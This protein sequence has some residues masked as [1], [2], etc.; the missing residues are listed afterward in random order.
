MVSSTI[1]KLWRITATVTLI[2]SLM[3]ALPPVQAE[4]A[5]MTHQVTNV[6]DK[7][8]AVTWTTSTAETGYVKYGTSAESLPSIASD[9]RGQTTEDDTHHVSI[10]SLTANTTY[11][12]EI[13]SGGTTYN[14]GGSPYE[15][16]TGPGLLFAMPEMI[17]GTVYKSDGTTAAEGTMLYAQIGTSQVLSGLVG[18]NGTWGLNI[19]PIRN[20]T[21]Q[22]YYSHAD[23]DDISLDAD[24]SADGTTSQTVTITQAKAGTLEMT[25][26]VSMAADFSADVLVADVDETIQFTDAT[27]GGVSPYTYEWDFNN[28]GT[29]DSTEASPTHAYTSAGTYTVSLTV[30]DDESAT[31]TKTR[32][33]Y[34][35][36]AEPLVAGFSADM[37]VADIDETI[38]FTDA[39]TGGT[40]PYTYR[41]DFEN[42]GTVD[43][44]EASPTHAYSSAGTYTVKLTVFDSLS[45]TDSETKTDYIN[46]AQTLAAAFSA[47]IVVADVDENIQFTDATAGG[48]TPY[49]YRWDFNNDGTIDSAEASPTHAY[50]SAGTYTVKLTVFD[51]VMR[52]DSE[53][54]TNYIT[55]PATLVANFTADQTEADIG[56]TI[57]FTNTSTGGVATFTYAWDFN[58]DGTI[59]STAANP[60]HVYTTDD[61]YTVS[62]TVTDSRSSEDAETKS[63]YITALPVSIT[64]QLTNIGDKAFTVTWFTSE[65]AVG[66]VKYGTSAGSLTNTASDDRGQATEDDTHHVSITGL[67]ANTTYYYVIV[68]GGITYNNG[69][70][71]YEVTTGPSL[72]FPMPEMINGTVYKE[73]GTTPAEGAIVYA[74][75]GTSQVLSGLADNSGTWGLS[76][77]SV[78]AADFQSYYTHADE[79]EITLQ[80][81]GGN[82]G[83]ASQ[84]VTIAVA[85]A[86]T[87]EMTLMTFLTADFTAN[88]TD[89]G[90]GDTIQ[91]TNLT[92]G[93][94]SPYTYEWDFDNDGTTDSTDANPSHVYTSSGTYTV[95]L[96]VTDNE[97]D[98][99]SETKTDYITVVDVLVSITVFPANPEI[100][101][102]DQLQFKAIGTSTD[103]SKSDITASAEINWTSSVTT[104]ADIAAGTGLASTAG[105][106]AGTTVITATH[107]GRSISGNTTLT[108]LADKVAPVVT[109]ASPTEGLVLSATSLTVSGNVDDTTA[110]ATVIVNGGT[111]AALSLD[112]SGDFSQA[113]VLSV[114]SNTVLVKAVDTSGNTGT[115]GTITVVVDPNKPDITITSP[116]ERALTNNA[117][118][119]VT[120]TIVGAE[121]GKLIFN[122]VSQTLT[123]VSG[124]FTAEVTLSEG[125]NVIVV[126]AYA[127]DHE[128]EA[129]YLGTSGVRIIKLDTTAAVITI[130]SPASG[131]VVNKAGIEV[132]GTVDDPAVTS[133][134]VTLN[135]GTPQAVSVVAGSFSTVITLEA[136]ANTIAVA[137]TDTAGNSSSNTV[138]ATLDTTK[139]RVTITSPANQLLTKLT[140]LDV[141]GTIS[142]TAITTAT[143]LLNGVS[144]SVTVTNGSFTKTVTLSS[145]VNTIEVTAT[146]IASNTGT[147]GEITVTVDTTSPKLT[148]GLNDPTDSITITVTS[149]E[150]LQSAPTITVEPVIDPAGTVQKIDINKW[151]RTD[152]SSA[153]PIPAGSYTITV[154]GTDKA[155]NTTT[156]TVTFAKQTIDVDG[157][158]PTTVTTDATTLEIE[159]ETAVNDADISVTQHLENPSGNAANPEGVTAAAVFVEIVA[160]PE[161]RDNLKQIYIEVN[162]DPDELPSGTDESTLRL[163]IW[164]VAAGIW[165]QVTESGVNTTENYIYG[166]ITHLSKYGGFGSIPAP[167][168]GGYTPYVPPSTGTTDVSSYV[169][170]EGRFMQTVRAY[171]VSDV[172][173][174]EIDIGTIGLQANGDPLAIITILAIGESPFAPAG[175]TIV[176]RVYDF[177]PDGATFKPA[178]A[179]TVKYIPNEFPAGV[180]EENLVLAYRDATTGEWV[181]LEGSVVDTDA[182]TI[183][184][185]VSH[186]TAFAILSSPARPA[187]ISVGSLTI[188]PAEVDAGAPVTISVTVSN[189]SDLEGDYQVILSINDT[190]V[191]TE[192]VTLAGGASQEV[193]FTVTRAVAGDYAVTIGDLSGSFTVTE[194]PVVTEPEGASAEFVISNLSVS[195]SEVGIGETVTITVLVSNS[196]DLEGTYQVVLRIASEVIA[197]RAVTLAGGASQEV[198]FTTAKNTAGGYRVSIDEESATFTVIPSMTPSETESDETPEPSR[199]NWWL[200]GGAIAAAMF[201]AL[202]ALL[203]RR[204]VRAS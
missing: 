85:K 198:I 57:Q 88:K 43:S 79:D 60:T 40:T 139:P 189:S 70:E 153:S 9:D 17:S 95:S 109:L 160:S 183:S 99:D 20:S 197:T 169:N 177:G 13:V 152:G 26:A 124:S 191:E 54:K 101:L 125:T 135:G 46:A 192:D 145:G 116:A 151:S 7:A 51:A 53:I 173:M 204:Q 193:T 77:A 148:I 44:T 159:T 115:S 162:Y 96:A 200:I 179:L 14:D 182:N 29:V 93:G 98:T 199:L 170:T 150:A 42:D 50:S 174:L 16:T 41:W 172:C 27:T 156:K 48:A 15:I 154:T 78:R 143:L 133:V 73:D 113:V 31:D 186:F 75:I 36:V 62:L 171:S 140:S 111:P 203:I 82:D 89:A 39:T 83:T 146:D 63:G 22:S 94:T 167:P 180:N 187:A 122:G 80:A 34:I 33:D 18:N 24:G 8:F 47:D 84:A 38:Q 127:T 121:T 3:L 66:Y 132:S 49:I 164:D 119:S 107:T 130:D 195:P 117:T 68:C 59:D 25:L 168:S 158:D 76:I 137:A 161:L 2:A 201:V 144:Q 12:Y 58:N 74:Q 56:T 126:T 52:A 28:D 1:V 196:G 181:I 188:A 106:T 87:L 71:P 100:T 69:G 102:G 86:G 92:A 110:T 123:P 30:T 176:G 55:I 103:G 23:G 202:L 90:V 64:H 114:G 157:V 118:L 131:S 112:G 5:D 190:V 81:R 136:G 138:Q 155:G 149:N 105:K 142:D 6:G 178:S 19:A 165:S 147:S 194:A 134:N 128:D 10:A 72:T 108:V 32:T 185:P 4:A 104:V 37:V 141:T 21:Y 35:N 91:F 166:T 163:Y 45:R 61:S 65:A 184:A 67:T 120:G 11:Y 97:S 129:D 175:Y